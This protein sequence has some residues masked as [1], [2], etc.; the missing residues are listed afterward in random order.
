MRHFSRF[1]DIPI[2]PGTVRGMGEGLTEKRPS[3]KSTSVGHRAG[4][5]AGSI[6]FFVF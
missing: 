5:G 3:D 1:C 2:R 6:S 4:Q